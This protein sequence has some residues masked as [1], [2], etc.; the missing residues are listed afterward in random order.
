MAACIAETRENPQDSTPGSPPVHWTSSYHEI[1][2][3]ILAS[4]KQ[5]TRGY[6]KHYQCCNSVPKCSEGLCK[7]EKTPEKLPC[8]HLSQ[9][10]LATQLKK[11]HTPQERKEKK[12]RNFLLGF[13]TSYASWNKHSGDLILKIVYNSHFTQDWGLCL[14]IVFI[15]IAPESFSVLIH[16]I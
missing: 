14:L 15:L 6:T 11:A 7:T 5:I 13:Y 4:V 1:H 9:P 3:P 12:K 8:K 10:H 16:I 2:W